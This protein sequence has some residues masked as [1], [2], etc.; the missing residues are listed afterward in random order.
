MLSVKL[1]CMDCV[2]KCVLSDK[3]DSSGRAQGLPRERLPYS[4]PFHPED[5]T[6]VCDGWFLQYQEEL[7]DAAH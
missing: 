2:D 1:K 3:S 5:S 7:S 4:K 6:S